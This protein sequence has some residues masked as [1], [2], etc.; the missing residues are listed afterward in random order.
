[1]RQTELM[2]IA[3]GMKSGQEYKLT[4]RD[5]LGCAE[6]MLRSALDGPPRRTD[7]DNFI[8]QATKNWGVVF[9]P[10]HLSDNWTMRKN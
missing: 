1:M 9:V 7:I 4:K 5:L 8:E 6:G 3:N 10:D 2:L